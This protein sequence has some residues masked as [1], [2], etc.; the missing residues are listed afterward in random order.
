MELW[1]KTEA[2]LSLC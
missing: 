1:R 2:K